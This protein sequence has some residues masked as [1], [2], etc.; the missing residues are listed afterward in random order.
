MKNSTEESLRLVK[1]ALSAPNPDALAKAYNQAL[2][3]TAYDLSY[4]IV[5]LYPVLTPIR[6]TSSALSPAPIL[7][8]SP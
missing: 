7:N 1:E 5:S 2:G 3:L 6:K 8:A 4:V